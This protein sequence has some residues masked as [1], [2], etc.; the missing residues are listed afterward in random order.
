MLSQNAVCCVLCAGAGQRQVALSS[1]P[2]WSAAGA[3]LAAATAGSAA[4][5]AAAPTTCSAACCITGPGASWRHAPLVAL[6][7]CLRYG[8]GRPAPQAALAGRQNQ[9]ARCGCFAFEGGWRS[10]QA[11]EPSCQAAAGS[12]VGS[13]R[14]ERRQG[15]GQAADC[16]LPSL[17]SHWQVRAPRQGL[18]FQV[19][20]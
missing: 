10:Q 13:R 6:Q 8:D 5:A 1:A 12:G 3:A 20:R 17:L 15:E 9:V 7:A 19:S 14:S 18:P 16:V 11:G 2:A 4:C